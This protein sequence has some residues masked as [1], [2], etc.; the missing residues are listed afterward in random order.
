MVN[1][2]DLDRVPFQEPLRTE[3]LRAIYRT[4]VKSAV[5][6]VA[7]LKWERGAAPEPCVEE[8]QGKPYGVES[9]GSLPCPCIG[10]IERRCFFYFHKVRRMFPAG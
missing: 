4:G 1:R 6:K 2:I 8:L 9:S 7:L 5:A 10:C 3:V